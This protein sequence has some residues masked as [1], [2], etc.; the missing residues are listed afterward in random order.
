MVALLGGWHHDS[1][2]R[3]GIGGRY[4]PLYESQTSNVPLAALLTGRQ[5]PAGEAL[6]EL[7]ARD[8]KPLNAGLGVAVASAWVYAATRG[9]ARLL[10]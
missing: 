2:F 7:L 1:R 8:V 6:R 4:D 3:R 5:G 10:R 9:R